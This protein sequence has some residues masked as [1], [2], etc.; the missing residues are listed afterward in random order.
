MYYNKKISYMLWFDHEAKEAVEF[1]TSF[2]PNSRIISTSYYGKEGFEYHQQPEHSIMSI[3]FILDGQ[4][5]TAING[6][7]HFTINPSISFYVSY[8]NEFLMDEIWH[9]L[10]DHGTVLIP[11]TDKEWSSRYGKVID[12]FDVTWHVC[13]AERKNIVEQK[14]SPFLSFINQQQGKAK[15]AIEFYTSIFKDSAINSLLCYDENDPPETPGMVKDLHFTLE[16]QHFL[17][18]DSSIFHLY[19]FSEAVSF[20][21]HCE[22]ESELDYYWDKLL[23][24]GEAQMCGWLKDKYGLSWQVIPDLYLELFHHKNEDLHHELM[25]ACF[26]MIK[27]DYTQLALL[28]AKYIKTT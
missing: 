24:G 25:Q 21:I 6:G 18:Q 4:R 22:N 1:Y 11:F 8:D 9:E 2:F 17:A 3:E 16:N 10:S 15:E 5:F 23:E 14:I 27:Y 20:V 12:R 7:P 28:K 19:D 26:K 13:L